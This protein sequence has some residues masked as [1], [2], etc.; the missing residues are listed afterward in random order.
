MGFGAGGEAESCD[1]TASGPVGRHVPVAAPLTAAQRATVRRLAAAY[2][3]WSP[4]ADRPSPHEAWM[5]LEG[6]RPGCAE[7]DAS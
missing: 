7:V 5:M 3:K 2:G 4:P 1:R 6:L